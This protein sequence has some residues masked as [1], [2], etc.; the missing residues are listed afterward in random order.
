MSNKF[1]KELERI[2]KEDSKG[3]KPIMTSYLETDSWIAEEV[4]ASESGQAG[5]SGVLQQEDGVFLK[6]YK[7]NPE[8]LEYVSEI[9]INGLTYQPI[10]NKVVKEGGILLPS[11]TEEYGDDDTLIKEIN[12]FLFEYIEVPP[13]YEAIMPYIVL[14]YWVA[15]KFPFIP[16]IHFLGLPGAGKSTALEVMGYICYKP[17]FASGAITLASIF[18]LANAFKGTLLLDEFELG[19]RGSDNYNQIVQLLKSGVEDRPVF[20]TEGDGK[21]EVEM[22]R[23]KSPRIFSSQS[24][25]NNA[26]LQSRT[27]MIHMS[28]TKKRLPLYRLKKFQDKALHLR[29]KLL[30]WRFRHLDQIEL[31]DI[32][33]G[34]DELQYFDRRVQQVI[35][36]IYYLSNEKIKSTILSLIKEQEVE[37][38][39]E[40]LEELDGQITTYLLTQ[41]NNGAVQL[42]ISEVANA[43]NKFREDQGYKSKLTG[44]FIGGIIRKQMGIIAERRGGEYYL[45]LTPKKIEELKEYYGLENEVFE[46]SVTS[47]DT[48]TTPETPAS[49]AKSQLEMDVE[50]VFSGAD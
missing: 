7:S 1:L 9:N 18:R 5:L 44:R 22:Y 49:P 6:Y 15:D 8:N 47:S 17:I 2:N 29:N 39:R 25:I 10:N 19:D 45:I 11:G 36:P 16:Y 30:L 41:S 14:F 23:I 48:R 12:D 27:I 34:F 42:T 4:L 31:E 20:R 46:A 33:S 24:P 26:A 38:K 3:D 40:R 13:F 43:L 37:T 50:E 32:E 28:K 21:K 35:T